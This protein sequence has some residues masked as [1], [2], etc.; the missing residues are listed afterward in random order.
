MRLLIYLLA[1]VGAVYALLLALAAV[2]IYGGPGLG[3]AEDLIMLGFAVIAFPPTVKLVLV[4]NRHSLWTGLYRPVRPLAMLLPAFMGPPR[5]T[6]AIEYDAP[7]RVPAY[8]IVEALAARLARDGIAFD[9]AGGLRVEDNGAT[10]W[11]EPDF[12][13]N[14]LTG[15]VEA[16]DAAHRE[17]IIAGVREF[18]QRD[19]RLTLV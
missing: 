18:L 5:T 6:F 10:W 9:N 12:S 1:E 4:G 7:R 14:R 13:A 11:I 3:G 2:F 8:D 17:Q 16:G 19:C 15:W